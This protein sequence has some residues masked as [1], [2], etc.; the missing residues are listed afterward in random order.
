MKLIATLLIMFG[1]LLMPG[2]PP[3]AL[4]VQELAEQVCRGN[5]TAIHCE[6]CGNTFWT[7]KVEPKPCQHEFTQPINPRSLP[8]DANGYS[9][10]ICIT[11]GWKCRKCGKVQ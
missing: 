5:V 9:L 10:A 1:N 8:L 11:D 3:T 7:L 2:N 4:S 6:A